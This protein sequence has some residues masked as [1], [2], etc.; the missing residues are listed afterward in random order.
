M[1]LRSGFG[2]FGVAAGGG[3]L[4]HRQYRFVL[5][6][7]IG[8]SGGS[9]RDGGGGGSSEYV[10]NTT[11]LEAP[12]TFLYKRAEVGIGYAPP[13]NSGGYG[14]YI[15]T[16]SHPS[17][18]NSGNILTAVGGGG[19]GAGSGGSAYDGGHGGGP[20]GGT[21]EPTSDNHGPGRGGTQTAGGDGKP[22][23]IPNNGIFLRGG[24][25]ET[26]PNHP[27]ERGGGGGGGYYGGGG[28]AHNNGGG[29]SGSGGGGSGY[30]NTSYALFVSGSTTTNG[31]GAYTPTPVNMLGTGNIPSSGAAGPTSYVFVTSA[32]VED[33][34]AGPAASK[35][36]TNL[37][38][39]SSDKFITLN[40]QTGE[41]T[42]S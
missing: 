7:G 20:A 12:V 4:Q 2:K 15:S 10:I 25:G 27:T 5:L 17:G 41:F 23:S 24:N 3:G 14:A 32:P 39:T 21:G 40:I 38:I 19:G 28:G 8:V 42:L 26:A 30:S 6:G 35:D 22:D 36:W 1:T 13:T 37:D 31:R 16:A 9:G 18:V 11:N 33:G 29:Q 34:T